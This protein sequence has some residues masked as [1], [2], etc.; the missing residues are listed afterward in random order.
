MRIRPPVHIRG[1]SFGGC[2]EETPSL[3]GSIW[4]GILA[5]EVGL[6]LVS[7]HIGLGSM[8]MRRSVTCY[9]VSLL[10]GATPWLMIAVV[11]LPMLP[12]LL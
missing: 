12:S 3:L 10:T 11:A 4:A 9:M 6:A 8:G 5:R 2:S 7:V 1:G